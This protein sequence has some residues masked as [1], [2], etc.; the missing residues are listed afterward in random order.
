MA[1]R[2]DVKQSLNAH[3]LCWGDQECVY[4]RYMYMYMYVY[5]HIVIH[6]HVYV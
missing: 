4:I 3:Q 6:V 2:L 1:L 5:L